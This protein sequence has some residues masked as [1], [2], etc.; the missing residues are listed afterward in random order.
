[1]PPELLDAVKGSP[2]L[3]AFLVI[4]GAVVWAA[5]K[6]G[7]VNGPVTRAW[8]S[9]QNRELNRIRREALL[10]AE[11]RKIAEEE[12]SGQVADL[13][14]QVAALRAET[15]WLRGE[16]EDHKRRDRIR[17]QYDH[18]MGDYVYGLLGEFRRAG[19]VYSDPPPPP[20]LSPMF[21]RPDDLPD[22]DPRELS[23][24]SP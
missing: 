21:I 2:F 22:T 3:L 8:N 10:R 16:N 6:I 11:R 1:M 15:S 4:L 18:R 23:S 14:A 24:S 19:G 12:R 5:E 7:G 17:D 13:S 9:W 20:D